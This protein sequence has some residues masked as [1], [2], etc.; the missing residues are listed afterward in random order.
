MRTLIATLVASLFVAASGVAVPPKHYSDASLRAV[1]FIDQNEGW[2][3]G[4]EGT[5]WHTI[6]AGENWER[7]STAVGGSLRSLDFI[8]PYIGWVVGREELPG[9]GSSGIILA[10]TDGGLKWSRI[11]VNTLP[12]LYAVK[13]FNQQQGIAAGDATDRFSS[14]V[15]STPD[16]GKSWTVLP[17]PRQPGWLT[18][19]FTDANTGALAGSWSSFAILRN[20]VFSTSDIDTFGG[21][22]ILGLRLYR[23]MAFAVGQGG[24]ILKS[25][26]S[27]GAKWKNAAPK[28]LAGDALTNCD[29]HCVH[30][31]GE[32]VWV[33]GRPGSFVLH[34][35]DY[36]KTWQVNRTGQNLPLHD[37][38]FLDMN[39]GWAVGDLGTILCT[40]D[41]GTTWKIQRRGGERAAALMVHA[42]TESLPLDTIAQIGGDGGYLVTAIRAIA[43]DPAS[44]P[45]SRAADLERWSHA[46]RQAGG[47]A[48]ECLWQFPL[49]T[50]QKDLSAKELLSVFD[51]F[52]NNRASEMMLRQMV[53]AI[54]MWQPELVVCDERLDGRTSLCAEALQQAF[55]QAADAKFFPEQ[56]EQLG[57]K[58]WTAKKLYGTSDATN[59]QNSFKVVMTDSL[60]RFG[61]SPR[62]LAKRAADCLDEPITLPAERGYSLHASHLAGA[63]EHFSVMDR[64][65]LANGGTAR[66]SQEPLTAPE[67]EELAE[68]AK[69]MQIKRDIEALANPNWK[70]VSSA[71]QLMGQLGSM[72]KQLRPDTACRS[73][74]SVAHNFAKEGQWQLAREAYQMMIDWYPLHPL[75]VDAYRWLACYSSS[76]AARHRFQLGQF[77]KTT[78]YMIKRTGFEASKD[79]PVKQTAGVQASQ[80]EALTPLPSAE[81]K[82]WYNTA[83]GLEAK[84]AEFGSIYLH[85]PAFQFCIQSARRTLGDAESGRKW[86]SRFVGESATFSP[87]NCDAWRSAAAAEL[88]LNT[89]TGPQPRPLAMCKQ[90]AKRPNLDGKL[91]DECWAH[92]K[93]LPLQN[94]GRGPG[95]E[96]SAKAKFTFD[97]EFL[98]IAVEC[99]HPAGKH[100]PLV[101]K[102]K[103]DEDLREYDR[104]SI[105]LD[106]DRNYQTYYRFEIDQ[107]GCLSE[108]CWGDKSWNPKWYVASKSDE[109][110]WTAEIAIPLVELTDLAVVPGQTWAC[111]V[112][113]IVPGKGLQAWSLPAD[114]EPRPEGMGLLMFTQDR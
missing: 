83:L 39:V 71:D 43:A 106:M 51:S 100:V 32:H 94:I 95:A 60:A 73:L 49:P 57:L 96:Y 89:H 90:T 35:A 21:R 15:Y 23:D 93:E 78:D 18:A 74:H 27:S 97:S 86:F 62:E 79:A 12:G 105:L 103:R 36:G 28:V 30:V 46:V 3:V 75:T 37:I 24:L 84:V 53:L 16:G 9:G 58:P 69:E 107:R 50:V 87:T 91:D 67:A 47:A 66:R 82:Y 81:V 41:G 65:A 1:K 34:S 99:K 102:R 40:T 31:F 114:V 108:D 98:Y 63:A 55:E 92:V 5:I 88:W 44:A 48:G 104:V 109:T 56:I 61:E 113:R 77:L 64:I 101:E 14:G 54:R 52:H 59:R 13:F 76:S 42:S 110:G 7:Q 17:G 26:D 11:A 8:T 85:D 4:D 20:N 111:N 112:V 19:D 70:A 10:T 68:H 72:L 38:H 2:A 80:T 45:M 22:N 33:A 25:E 6:D 29:F